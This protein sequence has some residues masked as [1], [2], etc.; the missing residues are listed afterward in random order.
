MKHFARLLAVPLLV[1]SF[2]PFAMPAAAATLTGT[3]V[4]AAYYFPNISTLDGTKTF[5]IGAGPEVSCTPSSP[6]SGDCGVLLGSYSLDFGTDTIAFNQQLSAANFYNS[7]AF[8]GWVFSGLSFGSGIT[9]AI[10]TSTGITGL[11]QSMLS[12]T[13]NS[14][15]LNLQG[16]AV[17]ANNSWSIK[18]G[19]SSVSAVPVPATGILM[20]AGLGGLAAMRRR[21][22]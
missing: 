8:N 2:L 20:L 13:S 10:L 17:S 7:A 11:T 6:K 5:T 1:L 15:T 14:I 9:S 4:T 19:T 18:L 22:G 21:R 16:L 3:T 12:F